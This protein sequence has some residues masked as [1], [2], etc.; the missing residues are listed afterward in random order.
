[1]KKASGGSIARVKVSAVSGG[2]KVAFGRLRPRITSKKIDAIIT[3]G[4]KPLRRH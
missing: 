2:M 3:T 4:F 1:M